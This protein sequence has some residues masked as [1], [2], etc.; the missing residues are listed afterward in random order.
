MI[1]FKKA[2]FIIFLSIFVVSGSAALTFFYFKQAVDSRKQDPAFRIV[3]IA[4]KSSV[5]E[6][7]PTAYLAELLG[8]SVDMPSN[9]YRFDLKSAKAMLESSPLI[10]E[11]EITKIK[12]GTLLIDYTLRQPVAYSGDLSN[13]AVSSD[14]VLIPFNPFFRPKKMPQIVTGGTYSWGQSLDSA[15]GR[16]AMELFHLINTSNLMKIDTSHAFD[17]SYG[18]REIIVILEDSKKERTL[19]LG[20]DDYKRGWDAYLQLRTVENAKFKSHI[21]IDLRI[22]DLAF[23]SER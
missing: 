13:T 14:G 8:L 23:I 12:P 3:A 10:R 1:S 4:Q 5:Y 18:R 16:L 2:I 22:P 15:E 7:L 19:R 21:V 9:L 11:A 6:P 17:P 20:T